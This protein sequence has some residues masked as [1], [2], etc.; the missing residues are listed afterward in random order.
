MSFKFPQR[1]GLCAFPALAALLSLSWMAQAATPASAVPTPEAV[2]KRL[3]NSPKIDEV[4]AL[5]NSNLLELRMGK[6]EIY[7]TDTN[8]K[9]IIKGELIDIQSGKNITRDRINDLE[10]I[11][12]KSLKL[13][14]SITL[15]RGNGEREFATFEDPNCGYCK[16]LTQTIL[17]MDNVKVHVF[18]Y[19]ILGEDS[20]KKS[21]N[22]WCAKDKAAT[23]LAWM[24]K[25]QTP[26][27]Q[28][29]CDT[30]AIERN[31]QFGSQAAIR[32]TPAIVFKSG[33]R[34]NGFMQ[35]DQIE[36]ALA[37]P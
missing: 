15:V 31:K 12:F 29:P 25:G 22:V 6:S 33:F 17:E 35:R 4:R 20:V 18:L 37:K 34:S 3:P 7:Y 27:E 32:G 23:Y 11:S 16:K 28:P 13:A 36:A 21:K 26:P 8:F 30:S 1:A 2:S 24:A 9:Y 19:P 5:Q 10:S 14:D